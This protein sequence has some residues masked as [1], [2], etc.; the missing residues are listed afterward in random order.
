LLETGTFKF[1]VCVPYFHN[2]VKHLQRHKISILETSE[3]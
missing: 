1:C 2:I 3:H